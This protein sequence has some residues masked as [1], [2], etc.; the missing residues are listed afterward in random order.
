MNHFP[1]F[2]P[3]VSGSAEQFANRRQVHGSGRLPLIW[4]LNELSLVG[5][6]DGMYGR[7]MDRSG[8][9]Y[10]HTLPLTVM[11]WCAIP[12]V[13]HSSSPSTTCGCQQDDEEYD[14]K[15]SPLCQALVGSVHEV[16]SLFRLRT[17]RFE[18]ARSIDERSGE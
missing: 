2:V 14:R 10:G 8:D 9:T 18:V 16:V 1:A 5:E 17:N 11:S 12:E 15:T 7:A 13:F 4:L 3:G 6:S